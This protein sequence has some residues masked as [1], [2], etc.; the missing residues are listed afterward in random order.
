MYQIIGD[1]SGL[2]GADYPM[3][4]DGTGRYGSIYAKPVS[5]NMKGLVWV[6]RISC[7]ARRNVADGASPNNARYSTAKRP[8]SPKPFAVA[9]VVTVDVAA[10]ASM[11]DRRAKCIRRSQRYRTGH[12]PTCSRQLTRSVRSDAPIAAQISGMCNGRS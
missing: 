6:F 5:A 12:M 1:R 10:S 9:I 7:A 4:F 2:F 8:S 11:N 3:S